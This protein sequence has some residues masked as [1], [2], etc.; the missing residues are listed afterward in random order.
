M[1]FGKHSVDETIQLPLL[2]WLNQRLSYK[3]WVYWDPP[4][5]DY[6]IQNQASLPFLPSFLHTS[7]WLSRFLWSRATELA[8]KMSVRCWKARKE[9]SQELVDSSCVGSSK[10]ESSSITHHTIREWNNG[11]ATNIQY[12]ILMSPCMSSYRK[13]DIGWMPGHLVFDFI[14]KG[15]STRANSLSL[16]LACR[17]YLTRDWKTELLLWCCSPSLFP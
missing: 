4:M 7:D 9:E 16:H 5:N 8:L 11:V 17:S 13:D 12:I 14:K 6:C 10:S 3:Y 1:L 2:L 15:L